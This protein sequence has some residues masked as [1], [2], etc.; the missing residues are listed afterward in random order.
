MDVSTSTSTGTVSTQIE[1]QKKATDVQE[2]QIT[3]LLES[4]SEQSQQTTAQKTG[5][6]NNI[7]LTA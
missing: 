2:K 5:I 7:N 4:A 3:K 1:A 6:G